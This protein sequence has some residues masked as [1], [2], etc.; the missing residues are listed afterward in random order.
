MSLLDRFLGPKEDG[1]SEILEIIT[2]AKSLMEK[3][4]F[5]RA[6]MEFSKALNK[7]KDFASGLIMDLYQETQGSNPDA[8]IALGLNILQQFPDN[9][10]MANLLGNT[11]RKKGDWNAAVKM[12]QRCLKQDPS[13][14]NAAYNIAAT[15]AR[16][17]VYDGNAVSAIVEFEKLTGFVL[18][19][20]EQGEE[21]LN[22][23]QKAAS[24]Y[25]NKEEETK[26]E[27]LPSPIDLLKDAKGDGVEQEKADSDVASGKG[28]N[29]FCRNSFCAASGLATDGLPTDAADR[30]VC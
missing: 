12:Y 24:A 29:A 2:Q 8:M 23:I 21:K 3:Q 17:D 15:I 30:E 28:K 14:T 7:D 18:P 1:K 6:A 10:E 11:Y 19:D 4:F 20:N 5:D 26:A 9:V 25:Q 22:E 27:S 16:A 13:H